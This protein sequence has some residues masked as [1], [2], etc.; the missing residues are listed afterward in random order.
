MELP[1]AVADAG[2]AVEEVFS[3]SPEVDT[4]ETS[5]DGS[6]DTSQ[7]LDSEVEGAEAE[8]EGQESTEGSE[9]DESEKSD[10]R[11]MPAK[12]RSLL[13]ELQAK[14]P[15][16]AKELKGSY[17]TA[18]S[19]Q[20]VF[21]SPKEAAK[22]K[23]VIESLGGEEGI[24]AIERERT[25]WTNVDSQLAN[26]DPQLIENIARDNPEGFA[27]LAPAVIAQF[28]QADP[29]GYNRV[30]AA[31]FHNTFQQRGG[32]LDTLASV[33]RC[34]EMGKTAEAAQI[35]SQIEA[36]GNGFE[37]T[38][39]S[40]PTVKKQDPERVKL[41]QERA[42]FQK[43][44]LTSFNQSVAKDYNA[45]TKTAITKQLDGY[46]KGRKIDAEDFATLETNVMGE[47]GKILNQDKD[48]KGQ[49]AKFQKAFDGDGIS[50]LVKSRTDKL[51][52]DAVKKVYGVFSRLGGGTPQKKAATTD[53][54]NKPGAKPGNVTPV[55]PKGF[56]T[57]NRMPKANE[58]DNARTTW[59][60]KMNNQAILRNGKKVTW[61]D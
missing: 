8:T 22:A 28:H 48:F 57:V 17:F 49:L 55:A 15:K 23:G 12:L 5:V 35:L 60:M 9:G 25:E 40:A 11:Q 43:Q 10:G 46:L 53:K 6:E 32:L 16:L 51:L 19:F 1:G 27:K 45:Y 61:K 20:T 39:N 21:A 50:R 36:W 47:I 3:D 52:P 56:V 4:V 30:M 7:E 38:A 44:K 26:G 42:E 54:A 18:K 59:E 31:V 29:E 24:Q 58:V 37:K 34:L 13:K 2:D 41:D 14:D 33:Q